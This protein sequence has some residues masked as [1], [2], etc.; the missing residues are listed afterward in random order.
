[1]K[2]DLLCSARCQVRFGQIHRLLQVGDDE[3]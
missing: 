2:T 1:M 3:E